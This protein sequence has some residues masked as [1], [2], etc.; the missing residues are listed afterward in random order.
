MNTLDSL[1]RRLARHHQR[2]G[3]FLA[4]VLCAVV[5]FVTVSAAATAATAYNIL[6]SPKAN[7][8]GMA[9]L[10]LGTATLTSPQIL[11]DVIGAFRKRFPAINMFGAQW[12]AQTLK[13]N[14][15]YTAH[16]ASYGS[17]STFDRSQGGYKNGANAAR[18]G[19]VDVAIVTDQQPTYPL[20]WQHL[21]GIKD[22]KNQYDK[23][24]AGGGY[25]LGKGCIDNGFFA[26]M[27]TRYFSQENVTA[28]AD[29]DYDWLQTITG[30]LNAKGVEPEG[31]VLFVNTAVANTLAVDPRM[32]SKDF[33]GQLLTGQGYRIWQNI[34]GFALIQEYP[35]LPSN[36]GSNLTSVSATASTD[37]LAKTAHGLV[38]GDPIVISAIGGGAAG[39]STATRYWVIKVDA[40][41]FK[42]ATTYANAIAGT[43]ID[44]TT[45]SSGAGLTLALKENLVAFA[46]D[47]RAF[48]SLAGVPEGLSVMEDALGV[49]KTMTFDSVT[50]PE[51]KITMAAAKW[52]EQG[53][54][55]VYFV[56]TFVY[57]TNAGKQGATAGAGNTA[58]ANSVLAAANVAGTACDYAGLRISS[59]AS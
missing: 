24:I 46:G 13:L 49:V 18:N 34:G 38:T 14:K 29:C 40:D 6:S 3:S 8:V 53:T 12:T 22:D 26:K 47:G 2:T 58:A 33:A 35:D 21:D 41:S 17:A 11:L 9:P 7:P 32:I 55:D 44:V 50:D 20:L 39:L 54:G 27:T 1:N 42:L 19:L 28:T 10:A 30:L 57:G 4:L 56:P 25:V 45:D 36:N 37:V 48:A 15:G 43:A 52:Q 31:R 5:A 23:V 51:S 16:I 59:G